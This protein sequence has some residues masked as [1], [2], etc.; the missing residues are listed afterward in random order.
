MDKMTSKSAKKKDSQSELIQ[1]K[2]HWGP[3]TDLETIYVNHMAITH[4]GPEF[5]LIFGE[6]PMPL[7]LGEG[8]IPDE[9]EIIPKVRLAI[10][11]LQMKN[12]S[13]AI[14]ENCQKYLEKQKSENAS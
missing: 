2:M 4:S 10:T 3:T 11:P 14:Y 6:L 7:V 5:Y 12:M 9:L 8:E 13:E 1:L